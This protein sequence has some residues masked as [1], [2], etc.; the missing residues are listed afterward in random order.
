[1]IK[2]H[3]DHTIAAHFDFIGQNLTHTAENFAY[4]EIINAYRITVGPDILHSRIRLDP[5]V[6]RVTHDRYYMSDSKLEVENPGPLPE[7]YLSRLARRWTPITQL[8]WW[9]LSMLSWG[10]K[11]GGRPIDGQGAHVCVYQNGSRI[12]KPIIC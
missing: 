3:E 11:N 1:M 8:D 4:L 12:V 2:L 7:S 9:F 6:Q 5:G 10:S